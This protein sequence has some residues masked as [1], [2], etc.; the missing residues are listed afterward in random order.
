M[1]W[2]RRSRTPYENNS[3]VRTR[4]CD[5][6]CHSEFDE[7]QFTYLSAPEVHQNASRQRRFGRFSVME[8]DRFPVFLVVDSFGRMSPA[9]LLSLGS[10][11]LV[12][13]F[14]FHAERVPRRSTGLHPS[15]L[16]SARLCCVA[17]RDAV[18]ALPE[19]RLIRAYRNYCRA[20]P[21]ADR[22]E[23]GRCLS[24]ALAAAAHTRAVVACWQP[25]PW[26]RPRTIA[27]LACAGSRDYVS[28]G[29]ERDEDALLEA[30]TP[31]R[32]QPKFAKFSEHQ[33]AS[34][35]DSEDRCGLCA[36]MPKGRRPQRGPGTSRS[37]RGRTV[38]CARAVRK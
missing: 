20:N 22:D 11:L 17:M 18:D 36:G 1:G 16:H 19:H 9:P 7:R 34:G 24:G 10:D 21:N 8:P 35:S 15:D 38:R 13:I 26:L 4:P 28:A 33:A 37:H 31:F 25:Y 5:S 32:V 27:Q 14:A 30:L 3:P 6:H 12:A 2:Y 23:A 29:A